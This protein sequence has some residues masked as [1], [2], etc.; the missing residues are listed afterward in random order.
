[1]SYQANILLQKFQEILKTKYTHLE[2]ETASFAYEVVGDALKIYFEWSNGA[3]D[4]KNNFDFP[5]KPYRDMKDR[6]YCH[7]G[8]LNVWKVIEP[9]LKEQIM[10]PKNTRIS[11]AG[12]SHGAAIALL[13]YEYCRF[14]RP[15][16]LIEGYGYGSPRVIWGFLKPDVKDRFAGFTTIRNKGDIVTHVPPAILGYRHPPKSLYT[17]GKKSKYGCVDAHKPENYI[18]E[19]EKEG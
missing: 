1:M 5:A 9:Y 11:I 10:N 16:C 19:L 13:C 14:H 3:T 6:W 15:D 8:F 18:A 4:W 12:Y 17:I 7:R 2:R